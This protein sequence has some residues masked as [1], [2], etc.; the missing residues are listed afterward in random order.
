[1]DFLD[2]QFASVNR[3]Q[4]AGF[5]GLEKIFSSPAKKADQSG[6]KSYL[7]ENFPFSD[8]CG[9]QQETVY[10]LRVVSN[11]ILEQKSFTKNQE[12]LALLDQQASIIADY[13][14][15]AIKYM[16]EVS[17]PVAP[18]I[19]TDETVI[20]AGSDPVLNSIPVNGSGV[21]YPPVKPARVKSQ[22]IPGVDNKIVAIAAGGVIILAIFKVIKF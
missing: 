7:E 15:K 1:M 5:L 19:I 17:C 13:L 22:V 14:A 16:D 10:E 11:R 2:Q 18:V 9:D 20:P 6:Y 3:A 12:Q 4:Y 8:N 21:I